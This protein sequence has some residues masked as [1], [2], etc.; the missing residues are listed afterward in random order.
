MKTTLLLNYRKMINCLK[1]NF[2]LF[3]FLNNFKQFNLG[4]NH[5]PQI[6]I[7]NFLNQSLHH[8]KIRIKQHHF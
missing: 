2:Y 6:K 3:M 8:I 5:Y 1:C 7:I 4:K